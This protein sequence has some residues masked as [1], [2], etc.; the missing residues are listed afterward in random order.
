MDPLRQLVVWLGVGAGHTALLVALWVH[1]GQPT[2]PSADA[3]ITVWL[4]PAA[5][6]EAPTNEARLLSPPAVA[7]SATRTAQPVTVPRLAPPA[8]KARAPLPGEAVEAVGTPP[9]F[10]ERVEPPYPRGA[11]LAGVQGV[12]RLVLEVSSSGALRRATV[13][14]SSGDISLDRAA[15]EAAQ[16]STYGPASVSGR[17]VDAVVEATYRFELR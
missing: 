3:T 4:L 15:V 6:D 7:P 16:A 14:S 9:V 8:S 11:R 17:A 13:V 10:V 2:Q 5:G 1:P 12:V